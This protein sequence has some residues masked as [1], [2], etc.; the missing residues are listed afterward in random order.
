MGE[1]IT[2]SCV[3]SRRGRIILLCNTCERSITRLLRQRRGTILAMGAQYMETFA[4][5][6]ILA[7]PHGMLTVNCIFPAASFV[8]GLARAAHDTATTGH[9]AAHTV[10]TGH[11]HAAVEYAASW[12]A[13]VGRPDHWQILLFQCGHPPDVL[14]ATVGMNPLFDVQVGISVEYMST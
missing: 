14:A 7:K 1:A 11:A 4:P 12:L 10:K 6:Y 3:R 13:R 2:T 5:L 8:L 9:A